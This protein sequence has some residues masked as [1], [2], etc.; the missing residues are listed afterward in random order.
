MELSNLGPLRS[1]IFDRD[2]KEIE[3]WVILDKLLSGLIDMEEKK[4][5]H[6]DLKPHNILIH[7]PKFSHYTD[8]KQL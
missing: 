8:Y 3:F 4:I 5:V 6:R 1:D 7:F 2:L